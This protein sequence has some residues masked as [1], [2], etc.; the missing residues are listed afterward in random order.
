MTESSGRITGDG[1][2]R[3]WKEVTMSLSEVVYQHLPGG[4][5]ENN[6]KFSTKMIGLRAE[7]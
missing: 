3:I 4:N 1:R 2:K 6:E 5:E 7:I